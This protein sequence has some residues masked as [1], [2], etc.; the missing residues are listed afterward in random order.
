MMLDCTTAVVPE[1]GP[2]A[3]SFRRLNS[4]PS[5]NMR[6][7]TPSSESVWTIPT[8]AT[9]GTGTCGPTMRPARMYPSTT[10]CRSRS[11]RT[12]VTAATPRTTTRASR[13]ACTS[14]MRP[15]R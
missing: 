12:V 3:T 13:N 7:M 10:G 14:P 6:R 4:S 11:K 9:S 15:R 2:T 5:A 1:V 8:S